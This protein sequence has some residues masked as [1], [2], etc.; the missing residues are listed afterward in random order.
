[1][2]P[3]ASCPPPQSTARQR[4][5]TM[6]PQPLPTSAT[7]ET[8]SSTMLKTD[9]LTPHQDRT[10]SH[11]KRCQSQAHTWGRQTPP[12]HRNHTNPPHHHHCNNNPVRNK[13]KLSSTVTT[14]PI[15]MLVTKLPKRGHNPPPHTLQPLHATL[16]SN[17]RQDRQQSSTPPG[18][19]NH[20][21]NASSPGPPVQRE[22][23]ASKVSGPGRPTAPG[24]A[25]PASHPSAGIRRAP[26]LHT[27][28]RSMCQVGARATE[29]RIGGRPPQ[30]AKHR[31]P[32]QSN[33]STPEAS[34]HAG[35]IQSRRH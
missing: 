19:S 34:Q 31:A 8:P 1:M 20:L 15:K 9:P 11:S 24:R 12:C 13:N 17:D 3:V 2:H 28:D 27:P 4:P 29:G 35:H 6:P 14:Q 10:N 25:Q 7:E 22:T 32:R 23:C 30:H 18:P 21:A 16:Q 33:T 26:P 5:R